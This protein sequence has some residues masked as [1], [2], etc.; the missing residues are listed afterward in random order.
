MR[1]R[2][3]PPHPATRSMSFLGSGGQSGKVLYRYTR[4]YCD[5]VGLYGQRINWAEEPEL[6]VGWEDVLQIDI[7]GQEQIRQQTRG[8]S[9]DTFQPFTSSRFGATTVGSVV[10]VVE[11]TTKTDLMVMR[12]DSSPS[13]MRSTRLGVQMAKLRNVGGGPVGISIADELTKLVALR[14][15]GALTDNEFAAQKAR[16]LN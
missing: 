12:F 13:V 15:A 11:I 4:F 1:L 7:T 16:L 14:D 9:R 2:K 5:D 8:R 6:I 3:D 10:C